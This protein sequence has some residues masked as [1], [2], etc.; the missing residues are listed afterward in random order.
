MESHL[1]PP[2]S[3]Q[4]WKPLPGHINPFDIELRDIDPFA[5]I[6]RQEKQGPKRIHREALATEEQKAGAIFLFRECILGA[7]GIPNT[8]LI[9]LTFTGQAIIGVYRCNSSQQTISFS[10]PLLLLRFRESIGF[11]YFRRISV[12]LGEMIP[13]HHG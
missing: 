7:R 13:V 3:K 2:G 1:E 6:V 9:L 4:R 5:D 11:K 8:F 12:K 10:F